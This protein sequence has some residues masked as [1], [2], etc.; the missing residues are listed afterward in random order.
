MSV[1][2]QPGRDNLVLGVTT[3]STLWFVTVVGLC[4]G[5]G[6]IALGLV[7]LALGLVVLSC[8]KWVERRILEDRSAMLTLIAE[9]EG[10][11]EEEIR[12]YLKAEKF[13]PQLAGLV[14]TSG[15]RRREISYRVS[16]GSRQGG[17]RPAFLHQLAQQPGMA[18]IDWRLQKQ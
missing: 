5:G 11:T 8:L 4:F 17:E 12:A 9:L 18:K 15:A 14:Y 13:T 2:A 7:A 1:A 10:P 3:A 16:W 6:Q